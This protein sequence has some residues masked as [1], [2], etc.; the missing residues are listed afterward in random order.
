MGSW[1]GIPL[2]FLFLG[3]YF[4]AAYLLALISVP[5][6]TSSRRFAAVCIYTYCLW[7]ATFFLFA[8]LSLFRFYLLF[9]MVVFTA[10]CL[11]RLAARRLQP[12]AE[13]RT[14]LAQAVLRFKEVMVSPVRILFFLFL[15]LV[16]LR[17][18]RAL[19]A[20]PL[21]WDSLTYHL[22]RA[23]HWVQ[24]GGWSP[25]LGPDFWSYMDFFQLNGDIAWAMAMLPVSGDALLAFQGLF[26]WF[27]IWI[28]AYSAARS[29]GSTPA[30]AFLLSSTLAV[31]PA[32]ACYAMSS[33]VNNIVLACFL[34]AIP[35]MVE[36]SER[37]AMP[38]VLLVSSA[39]SFGLGT[40]LSF[41]PLWAMAM[42]LLLS[43]I[44]FSGRPARVRLYLTA[45]VLAGSFMA[46]PTYLRAY[47]WT[48]SPVYPFPLNLA[49]ARRRRR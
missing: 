22:F 19:V 41:A 11:H 24:S 34:L 13:L 45:I 39:F 23:G 20:P 9:P 29:L 35:F 3:S 14:D 37:P 32:V 4:W 31:T 12:I 16:C 28:G 2:G 1:L 30:A 46:Q 49:G 27:S 25:I 36:V 5:T 15:G 40:Q 7:A 18:L 17:F 38:P 26:V 43:S 21:A 6:A 47:F 8:P 42:A 48:G 33:Y 44:L 10:A